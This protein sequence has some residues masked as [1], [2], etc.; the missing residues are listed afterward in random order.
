MEKIRITKNMTPHKTKLE[1]KP[2]TWRVAFNIVVFLSLSMISIPGAWIVNTSLTYDTFSL[3]KCGMRLTLVSEGNPLIFRVASR[4]HERDRLAEWRRAP[5]R[6][7]P[8]TG[9]L[10]L[11]ER[12]RQLPC[13][14]NLLVPFACRSQP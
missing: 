9:K 11:A 2:F 4:R 6:V 7:S 14:L 12:K 13:G 1:S 10:N 5:A 3:R 8:A